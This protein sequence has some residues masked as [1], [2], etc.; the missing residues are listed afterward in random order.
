MKFLKVLL[1]I[2]VIAAGVWVVMCLMGPKSF[3]TSRSVEIDAPAEII[4]PIVSDFSAWNEW[5]PWAKRDSTMKN[6]ISSPSQ[7]VGATMAW[8]SD[9]SG[10]GSMRIVDVQHNKRLST[11]LL[12]E[13]YD[14]ESTSD[15]IL[16]GN[17][18]KTKL[19]WTM[20]SD[21]I[22]FLF[23]GFML[24][25]GGVDSI[26]QDYDD[27]LA[28]IKE[29]AEEDYESRKAA[30]EEERRRAEEEATLETEAGVETE[31]TNMP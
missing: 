30:E 5:S 25:A 31:D 7:G 9:N 13:G 27:G 23:R 16:E 4:F 2:V 29:I 18:E 14:N 21:E 28:S 8:V 26:N 11:A 6:T 15:F 20:D 22:P 1:L 3:E 12:F 24:L 10:N 19:S 17:G